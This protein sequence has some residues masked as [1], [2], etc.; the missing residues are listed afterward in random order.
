MAQPFDLKSL[1][2][3]GDALPVAEQVD[4]TSSVAAYFAASQNGVLAYKSGGSS[5][6]AQ[7]TWFDHSGK[8]QTKVGGLADQPGFSLSADGKFVSTSR[9][10]PGGRRADI[11]ILDLVRGAESRLTFAG[12]NRFPLWSFDGNSVYF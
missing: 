4:G 2:T 10:E 6:G 3:T 12:R 7:L 11:W 9:L 8:R 1:A 5:G